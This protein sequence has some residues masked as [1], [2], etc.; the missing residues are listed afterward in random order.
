M[1]ILLHEASDLFLSWLLFVGLI[2][3]LMVAVCNMCVITQV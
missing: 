2:L 3:W 1:N